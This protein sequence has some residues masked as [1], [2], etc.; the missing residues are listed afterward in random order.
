M[1]RHN[2]NKARIDSAAVRAQSGDPGPVAA[3]YS[4]GA[5]LPGVSYGTTVS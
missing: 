5:P 4:L 3:P 1:S 2:D